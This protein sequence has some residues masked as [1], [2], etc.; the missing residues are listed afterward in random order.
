MA[1][2]SEIVGDSFAIPEQAVAHMEGITG[3]VLARYG[4]AWTWMP[5]S[6]GALEAL[7]QKAGFAEASTIMIG[8]VNAMFRGVV[9]KK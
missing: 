6:S 7:L 8:P 9:R 5:E 1:E 2:R 4:T 3:P